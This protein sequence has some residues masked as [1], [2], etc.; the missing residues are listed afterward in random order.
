MKMVPRLKIKLKTFLNTLRS[1]GK[2][3]IF[4]IGNNKTGTTSL[5][6]EMELQG[7][8]VGNQR[9]AEWLFDDWVKKDFR[10][11]IRYCYTA[12]FFQ[13]APFSLPYTFIAVDQALPGSKFILTVRDNAEEWYSSLIRFHGK[14]WGNGNIPPTA[15]DLKEATYLYKGFP[16]YSHIHRFGLSGQDVY[17]KD[18]LIEYYNLHNKNVIDYFKNRQDDL[19]IINIKETEDYSR[20]CHFIGSRQIRDSFPWENKT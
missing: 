16:Y 5:K 4:C 15:E 11:L 12:R 13:D 1:A 2:Q 19:L 10:R 17:R 8:P 14:L 6:M 7:Y 18:V 9:S 20:F 3:K